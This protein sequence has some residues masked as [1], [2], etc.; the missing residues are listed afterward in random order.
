[1]RR[2]WIIITVFL[3]VIALAGIAASQFNL[4]ALPEPGKVETYFATKGKHFL[5]ARGSRTVPPAPARSPAAA[6]EGDKLYG[7]ECSMCHG[8]DGRT[9]TGMGRELYPRAVDLGSPQVQGYSDAELFWIVKNGIRLSGMPAFG[10]SESDDHIWSIV[11][12]LRTLNS[13][14]S[15]ADKGQ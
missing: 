9:P 6:V 5:V 4:S 15:N 12:Y 3:A 14:Q 2:K 1:V 7:A 8:M 11:Q 13:P 10:K